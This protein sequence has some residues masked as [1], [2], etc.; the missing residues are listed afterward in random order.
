MQYITKYN[1]YPKFMFEKE[2][3]MKYTIKIYDNTYNEARYIEISTRSRC[4]FEAIIDLMGKYHKKIE[5]TT[6][7]DD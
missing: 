3:T 5:I 1:N 6:V 2:K 4:D 7:N